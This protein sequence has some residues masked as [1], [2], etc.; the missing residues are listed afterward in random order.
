MVNTVRSGGTS[1]DRD[2]RI[3]LRVFLGKA[4]PCSIT[5]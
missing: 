1:R 4:A 2:V 3:D 5:H